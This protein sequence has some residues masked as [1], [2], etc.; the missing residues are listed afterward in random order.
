MNCLENALQY[1][2]DDFNP[3]T[4]KFIEQAPL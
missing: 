4:L 3:K 1:L 2:M